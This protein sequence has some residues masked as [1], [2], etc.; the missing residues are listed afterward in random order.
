MKSCTPPLGSEA[1]LIAVVKADA[2]GH[3]VVACAPLLAKAGAQWWGTDAEEGAAVRAACPRS[4]ILLM[5]G[6]FPGEAD[7]VIDQGLTPVVWE[8]WHRD[9][10][11]GGSDGAQYAAGELPGSPG[12]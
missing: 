8:H 4:R 1:E 5:S 2:Y 12:A 7:T 3:Y 9:P 11:G 10:A 6:I